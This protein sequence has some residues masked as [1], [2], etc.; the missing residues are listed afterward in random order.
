MVKIVT[1]GKSS[2]VRKQALRN[3]KC[4]LKDLLLEESAKKQ[5]KHKR[6]ILKDI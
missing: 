3:P 6:R 2:R 4:V 5:A 1:G